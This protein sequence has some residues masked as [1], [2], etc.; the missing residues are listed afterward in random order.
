MR[1]Q[2]IDEPYPPSVPTYSYSPQ[3]PHGV[4]RRVA[5]GVG[6]VGGPRAREMARRGTCKR[7][8]GP[9]AMMAPASLRLVN[10]LRP[11]LDGPRP[12]GKM[13]LPN[14]T[15]GP[16]AISLAGRRRC[17]ARRAAPSVGPPIHP[18]HPH[19]PQHARAHPRE[20]RRPPARGPALPRAPP[21]AEQATTN[22]P[23]RAPLHAA[24]SRSARTAP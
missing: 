12:R 3:S 21:T 11:V 9:A 13:A 14:V 22:P 8:A 24:G 10:M 19:S 6:C 2:R 20:A 17:T 18:T 16:A 15:R 7:T 4:G 5:T 23:D 1:R